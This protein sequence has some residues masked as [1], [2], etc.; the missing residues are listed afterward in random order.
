MNNKGKSIDEA[1]VDPEEFEVAGE[2]KRKIS[3][4][5]EL[6]DDTKEQLKRIGWVLQNERTAGILL[7]QDQSTTYCTQKSSKAEFG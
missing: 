4:L 5:K 3:G 2:S 6:D 1:N 7:V